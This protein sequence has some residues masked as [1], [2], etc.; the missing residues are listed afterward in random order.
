MFQIIPTRN[1]LGF[2]VLY[3]GIGLTDNCMTDAIYIQ[4]KANTL[5]SPTVDT[6][7]SKI[8]TVLF[9][10]VPRDFCQRVEGFY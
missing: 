6:Q 7:A 1:H 8:Y 10:Y 5:L 9:V 3:V 4:R 2:V